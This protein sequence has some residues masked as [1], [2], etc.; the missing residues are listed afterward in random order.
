MYVPAP[1]QM[2]PASRSGIFGFQ[3]VESDDKKHALCEFVAATPA[4][5]KPILTDPSVK[6]FLKGSTYAPAQSQ[7]TQTSCGSRGGHVHALQTSVV[8]NIAMRTLL[9]V[10]I[11]APSVAL[12][13]NVEDSGLARLLANGST[14]R[15]AIS[16]IIESHR[17]KVTVLISW[18]RT[19]PKGLN[20][21]EL[22]ILRGSMA[23]IFGQSRTKEAIPFLIENITV[24]PDLQLTP[25]V[26]AKG[27]GAIEERMPAISALIRIGPPA[28]E[29]TAHWPVEPP[30]F[31]DR[32][33]G[34]YVVSRLAA[35][36]NEKK[37]TEEA[38]MYIRSALAE[39]NL[40][41]SL[42]EEGMKHLPEP[43]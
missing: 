16:D 8:L 3:C 23:E 19:P 15:A 1:A 24:R 34:I 18:T 31:E 21:I 26:W 17:D 10:A 38:Y 25:D 40:Q 7:G 35:T 4:P 37:T 12:T 32:L 22:Y 27:P 20:D 41:R 43:H 11:F 28:F 13:Q 6:A 9:L 29:A 2:N 36:I 14:R 39:A 42:A 5:L 33:A 30:R